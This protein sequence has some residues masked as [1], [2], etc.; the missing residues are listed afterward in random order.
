[1]DHKSAESLQAVE[2]YT[3]NELSETE[4][5]QFEEHMFDCPVCSEQVRRN[6]ALVE[7]LKEV[8]REQPA[9][10]YLPAK[11]RIW[12]P[13]SWFR[14]ASFVPTFAAL[15]L[16]CVVVFQNAAVTNTES[17]RLLPLANV[18]AP[19]SRGESAPVQL[20]DRKSPTFLITFSVDD[21]AGGFICEFV[22]KEGHK[23]LTLS[24]APESI[25]SFNL[26]VELPSKTFPPGDYRMIL[27]PASKPDSIKTYPFVVAYSR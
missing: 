3:L 5:T 9:D 23:L 15:T 6:Y 27:R 20:V 13:R 18:V 19:V 11:E 26:P 2:K 21:L 17:A 22:N 12:D 25:T 1:M 16:A 10:S 24:S 14:P 4:R 8:L 7:N